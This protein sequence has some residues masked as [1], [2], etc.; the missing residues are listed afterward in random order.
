MQDDV[1]GGTLS[2]AKTLKRGDDGVATADTMLERSSPGVWHGGTSEP[3]TVDP[4]PSFDGGDRYV[5]RRLLGQGGMGEVT[6]SGDQW[7][8]RDVAVKTMRGEPRGDDRARFLREAC[9]QGQLEHPSVVPVYDLSPPSVASPFFTMKRVQGYTLREVLDRLRA[10]SASMAQA[11]PRG[12]LL[13][14][15]SQAS[16]AIAFAHARGVIHR[17]LKPD[18]IMLGEFGEVYVLDWGVAKTSAVDDVA[19]DSRR[20]L[21][22]PAQGTV[23]T[24]QGS[25][26]GT[27][28]YMSPEQA[29][30]EGHAV[31]AR[32][33]VYS[34]GAILFEVLSLEPLHKV[35]PLPSMLLATLSLQEG[36]PAARAQ[37][38]D[39]PPELDD[40]TARATAL[41]PEA[42]LGSMR[43]LADAITAHLDGERDVER[44]REL[45]GVHLEAVQR[46]LAIAVGGG[47]DA[48]KSR[49]EGL[50]ELGRAL[51]LDP[52]QRAVEMLGRAI[53]ETP[54]ELPPAAEAEL[55]EV[56]LRDRAK[57]ARRAVLVYA[58]W[59]SLALFVLLLGVKSWAW[60]IM[61][62]VFVLAVVAHTWWMARSGNTGPKHMRWNM[63][64]NFTIVGMLSSFVGP[65]F[66][67]PQIAVVTAASFMVGVRAN[68]RTRA[69]LT[70]LAIASFSVPLLLEWLGFVPRSYA[71]EDGVIK[72]LPRITAFPPVY[73]EIALLVVAITSAQITTFMVGRSAAAMV[74]AERKNLAQAY[75]LRQL[76]P[77]DVGR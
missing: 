26:V 55:K 11:F 34:M 39:I 77:A 17:D 8:G 45:A 63:I 20:P 41:D 54:E 3:S 14:A 38:K 66:I 71:F 73:T 40:L 27:P 23:P 7:L 57:S 69:L 29:R 4:T 37:D 21:D 44:R 24:A 1:P 64:L 42:R 74:E 33:D 67:V 58:L 5:S 52:S 51:A 30:G 15:L 12:R 46:A 62:D 65:L 53:L 76:L 43:D 2:S 49:A 48:D 28:G 16:L 18:N 75:R 31:T 10:G 47:P 60:T 72:I 9:I 50:R 22:T 6:L 59:G 70:G 61:T 36:R 32:S 68:Y 25:L 56:E 13:A 19:P 35:A